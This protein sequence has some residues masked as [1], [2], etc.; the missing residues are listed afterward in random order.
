[1]PIEQMREKIDRIDSK[2]V[3]LLE[4]RVDLAKKIGESK[5]KHNMPIA[6]PTREQEILIRVTEN[7]KL[8]KPF[9]KKIFGAIIEYCKQNE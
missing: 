2:I 6:D 1:M 7:T 8:D 4:E 5:R 9:L 3:K